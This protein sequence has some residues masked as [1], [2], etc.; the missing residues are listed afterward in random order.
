[1]TQPSN[2]DKL[3]SI[4]VARKFEALQE[5]V[6]LL[7]HEVKQTLVDLRGFIME[8]RTI[9]PQVSAEARPQVLPTPPEEPK[10]ETG[11]KVSP[12]PPVAPAP[13]PKLAPNQQL[14]KEPRQ[15]DQAPEVS[16]AL[17]TVMLGELIDWLSTAKRCGLS[18]HQI[19]PYVDAYEKAGYLTPLVVKV[20]LLSMADLDQRLEAPLDKDLLPD[21]YFEC[22]REFHGIVCGH[23]SSPGSSG[24]VPETHQ[25]GMPVT[26]PVPP[27][28]NGKV[29]VADLEST[30][31]N[32]GQESA[33]WDISLDQ[34]KNKQNKLLEQ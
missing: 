9:L 14:P 27:K 4:D 16:G 2:V 19:T 8:S 6:D 30:L 28:R 33:D 10:L 29:L 24:A 1:M 3:V 15:V 12:M 11:P 17:N 7:K 5:E 20:I 13:Q 21:Q 22:V 25:V 23:P 32:T 31:L 18:L 34:M 26:T